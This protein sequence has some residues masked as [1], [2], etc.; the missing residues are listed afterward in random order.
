MVSR[1]HS[2]NLRYGLH[3]WS[4]N[5]VADHSIKISIKC[6]SFHMWKNDVEEIYPYC[7]CVLALWVSF[8][9]SLSD[10][11][12]QVQLW[13]LFLKTYILLHIWNMDIFWSICLLDK[14]I[15][16]YA[17]FLHILSLK[18]GVDCFLKVIC[19]LIIRKCCGNWNVKSGQS[20]FDL[21]V[22]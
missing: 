22:E 2:L 20:G 6:L 12:A 15:F 17:S 13:I 5:D 10:A 1:E 16:I 7:T 4:W 19:S 21:L 14:V 18:A 9:W 3:C 8:L 11:Q